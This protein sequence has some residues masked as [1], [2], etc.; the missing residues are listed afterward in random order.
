MIFKRIA[1]PC[2]PLLSFP[3]FP[4]QSYLITVIHTKAELSTFVLEKIEKKTKDW[5]APIESFYKWIALSLSLF[6]DDDHCRKMWPNKP[7]AWKENG[8]SAPHP[9]FRPGKKWICSL[10][11]NLEHTHTSSQG[12]GEE[13]LVNSLKCSIKPILLL[14]Q[15]EYVKQLP[16]E[17]SKWCNDFFNV[18]TQLTQKVS[19]VLDEG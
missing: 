1:C 11:L 10:Y 8:P 4:T 2:H 19:R 7:S 3:F 6:G 13:K 9:Y 16:S 14:S 18:I 5:R 17:K 12:E 15:K